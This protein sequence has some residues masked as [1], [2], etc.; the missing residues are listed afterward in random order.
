M[1][2]LKI[3]Q[4]EKQAGL[5]GGLYHKTQVF[6]TYNTNRIEG[7]RL[8]EEQTRYIYETNT[9]YAE[10]GENTANIDDINETINHFACFDYMLDTVN[11]P[12][13][14]KIIKEFHK[15]LKNN[16]SQSKLPWFKVG[17]Y[18]TKPN[19]VGGS[20]T[21]PPEKVA[22]EMQKLLSAYGK[23]SEMTFEDIVEFHWAF[24]QIHPFQ[25][26]NGRVG[27][28]ILFRECLAHNIIPFIIE[29]NHKFYYYRGLQEFESQKAYLFDTCLSAQDRYKEMI[30]YFYPEN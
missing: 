15:F 23:K 16:T 13:S 11:E 18:K 8:S 5:K 20:E 9:F 3:L 2:V 24:E 10:E 7:S 25:D 26:G 30:S 27:R 19:I 29:D 1:D 12:L 22:A 17:D 4:E 28:L 21:T 6:L 14:E